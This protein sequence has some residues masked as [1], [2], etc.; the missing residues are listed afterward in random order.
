MKPSAYIPALSY[1]WLSPYYDRVVG[2]TVRETV[3]KTA[4]VEQMRVTPQERIL[5]LG[6]GT[7]TL[8]ILIK[9]SHPTADVSGIDGDPNI[10]A[11]AG[12]KATAAGAEI[13]FFEGLSYEMLYENGSF[14]QIVSSL[15][16]HHL[17]RENKLTTLAEV[18][19]VLKKGGEF[20]VG[21]WGLPENPVMKF[22]SYLVRMLDGFDTTA[23]SFNGRLPALLFE[24]GFVD[25]D[26]TGLF[27][28]MFGTIR[29]HRCRKP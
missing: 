5:D 22:L 18:W 13:E 19:R 16:F 28:T 24:A 1:D 25:I 8:T 14:D 17:T 11:I 4:L 10:L 12:E 6:C 7:G 21:D 3:F 29:L 27:N 23:D 15:F 9:N 26:E 20:H 2:L